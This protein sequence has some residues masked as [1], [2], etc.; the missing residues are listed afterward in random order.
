MHSW[1]VHIRINLLDPFVL[2]RVSTKLSDPGVLCKL[3][4]KQNYDNV[5]CKFLLYISKS[6]D[7]GEKLKRLVFFL[8]IA[9]LISGSPSGTY[10][11]NDFA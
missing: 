5:D 1:R 6:T 3:G 7:F 4:L 8:F 10:L 9:D 11:H 2:P